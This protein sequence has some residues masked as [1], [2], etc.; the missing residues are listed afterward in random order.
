MR[1]VFEHLHLISSRHYRHNTHTFFSSSP[2]FYRFTYVVFLSLLKI[3][4]SYLY[5]SVI[6]SHE[7]F[8]VWPTRL[9]SYTLT[10][11]YFLFSPSS[12]AFPHIR[13]SGS[14]GSLSSA[15]IH[16]TCQ[17]LVSVA[18]LSTAHSCFSCRFW[19]RR[20]RSFFPFYSFLLFPSFPSEFIF[21]FLLLFEVISIII[22]FFKW[23]LSLMAFFAVVVWLYFPC[24]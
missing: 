18:N 15:C 13:T 10:V 14:S 12:S 9:A 6:T 16:S 24:G 20:C 5:S 2:C 19:L 7:L 8:I 22:V 4:L 1:C 21:I 23:W 11:V 3:K 17:S